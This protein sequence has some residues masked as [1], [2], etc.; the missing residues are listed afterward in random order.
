MTTSIFQYRDRSVEAIQ[1]EGTSE[2]ASSIAKAFDLTVLWK[3]SPVVVF[4]VPSGL[5]FSPGDYYDLEVRTIAVPVGAWVWLDRSNDTIGC[6]WDSYVQEHFVAEECAIG[7]ALRSGDLEP[8]MIDFTG[9]PLQAVYGA[10]QKG[11]TT[12][13]WRL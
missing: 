7:V 11:K 1:Y 3:S 4:S 8:V 10:P 9:A 2:C 5:N 12:L 6:E 13:P